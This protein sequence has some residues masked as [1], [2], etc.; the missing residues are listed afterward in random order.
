MN[1]KYKIEGSEECIN[2]KIESW[3]TPKIQENINYKNH[4][5][6]IQK[7]VR[8]MTYEYKDRFN[9]DED[10]I[11]DLDI[12]YSGVEYGKLSYMSCQI[13]LF[14][15][16][17]EIDETGYLNKIEEILNSDDFFKYS[18]DKNN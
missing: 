2:I 7:K 5:K 3:C 10:Y 9:Y 6:S 16:Q 11:V 8:Q 15:T 14:K 1:F 4:I 18:K 17:N 12:R 13:M